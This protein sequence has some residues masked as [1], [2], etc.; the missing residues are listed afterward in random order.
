MEVPNTKRFIPTGF[1]LGTTLD[2]YP[3]QLEKRWRGR[4]PEFF[5][6]FGL[7]ISGGGG[8]GGGGRGRGIKS[9]SSCRPIYLQTNNN[10]NTPDY[11]PLPPCKNHP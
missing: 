4:C 5:F 7:T 1:E 10:K 8:G 11:K 3:D 6:Q 2:G 9:P